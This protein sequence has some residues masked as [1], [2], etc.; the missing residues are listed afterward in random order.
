M[1]YLFFDFPLESIHKKAMKA[2]EAT[3]C[4]AEDGKY[5]EMHDLL[6]TDIKALEMA[7][8]MRHAQTLNLDSARFQA[9]LEGGIYV[10]EIRK[11]MADGQRGGVRGTPTFLVGVSEQDPS[12][13][14]ILKRIR[15]AQPYPAFKEV[16]DSLLNLLK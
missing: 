8:L 9:C 3:R 7:D 15:G 6:F 1:K 13:V 11:D 14:K 2:S 12:R 4:A 10:N 16:F 5:W